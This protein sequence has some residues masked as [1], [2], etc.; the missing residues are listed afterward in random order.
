[1]DRG[2]NEGVT[3]IDV[4]IIETH[5]DRKVDIR[6]IDNHETTSILMVTAGGAT[7]AITGEVTLIVLQHAHHGKNET[8]HSS[9]RIEHYNKILHDHS[10][11]VDGGKHIATLDK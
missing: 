7:L 9:P 8:I 10:I 6:G 3:G 2:A 1:M 4:R 5:S 11:K